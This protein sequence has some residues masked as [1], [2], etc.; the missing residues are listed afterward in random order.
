MS[1]LGTCMSLAKSTPPT[2]CRS[3]QLRVCA[4]AAGE[5]CRPLSPSLL[6][7]A[8]WRRTGGL[9]SPVL[10]NLGFT[11]KNTAHSFISAKR[12]S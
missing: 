5:P 3:F 12:A 11:S 6:V 1:L 7:A 2:P 9:H 10:A 8:L 4:L